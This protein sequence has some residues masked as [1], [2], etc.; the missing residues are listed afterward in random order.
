MSS[1]KIS[2]KSGILTEEQIVVLPEKIW[3]T[4]PHMIASIQAI[5]C[6]GGDY[7]FCKV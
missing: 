4:W 7:G 2:I 1:V 3:L 6:C 5:V